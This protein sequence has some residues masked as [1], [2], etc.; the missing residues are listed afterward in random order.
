MEDRALGIGTIILRFGLGYLFL[1]DC[2]IILLLHRPPSADLAQI[3]T[4]FPN[5]QYLFPIPIGI[6]ELVVGL[7][8]IFGLFTKTAATLE[9]IYIAA[10]T[11]LVLIA[12]HS[13]LNV[14]WKD[15]A[16]LL[17]SISLAFIGCRMFGIDMLINRD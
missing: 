11:T 5:L 16:L 9:S 15:I 4:K 10:F 14:A 3:L 6:F 1:Y 12:Y 17:C 2:I 7:L 8:L 13:S